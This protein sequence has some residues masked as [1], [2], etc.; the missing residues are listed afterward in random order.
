M[1]LAGL[2]Q[3]M[4]NRFVYCDAD[5]KL[6]KTLQEKDLISDLEEFTINNELNNVYD[7]G[8]VAIREDEVSGVLLPISFQFKKLFEQRDLLLKTITKM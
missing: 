7:N 2:L 8:K 4:E 1:L 5:F 6:F 3:E